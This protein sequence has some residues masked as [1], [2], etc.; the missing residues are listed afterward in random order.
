MTWIRL[1][2]KG[3]SLRGRGRP[4][5]SATRTL[6][7]SLFPS[8]IGEER[9]DVVS[10]V[11]EE[12]T[13][14]GPVDS[15]L[16]DVSISEVMVNAPDEVYFE[17][18]GVIYG[19]PSASATASTSCGSSSASSLRSAAASMSRRRMWTPACLMARASTS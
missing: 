6:I 11:I 17:S 9:E 8:L 19:L 16:K 15:L 13:G 14:F 4:S 3:W 7:S 10:R 1:P 2:W 12:A 18:D 5:R